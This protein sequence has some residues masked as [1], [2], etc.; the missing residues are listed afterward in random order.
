MAVLLATLAVSAAAS[1]KTLAKPSCQKPFE[2]PGQLLVECDLKRPRSLKMSIAFRGLTRLVWDTKCG[3]RVITKDLLS[4]SRPSPQTWLNIAVDA[5]H[6]KDVYRLLNRS[7]RCKVF[8]TALALAGGKPDFAAAV[9]Y[10]QR[11]SVRAA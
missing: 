3:K 7:S 6:Y 1:A 9:S 8:L 11:P 5:R 10:I 2:Q 4:S